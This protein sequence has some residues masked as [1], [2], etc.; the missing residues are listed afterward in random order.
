[1]NVY[2]KIRHKDNKWSQ[3]HFTIVNV[4]CIT[5]T[6][7]F[8]ST[9]FW[10]RA[11]IVRLYPRFLNSTKEKKNS[12]TIRILICSLK[13]IFL[14]T[15]LNGCWSPLYLMV[16]FSGISF[17][18]SLC[19]YHVSIHTYTIELYLLS[20]YNNIFIRPFMCEFIWKVTLIVCA[21]G[22]ICS[23]WFARFILSSQF[24]AMLP[25]RWAYVCGK[26]AGW[27]QFTDIMNW[28]RE[29]TA[30]P[31]EK[32]TEYALEFCVHSPYSTGISFE[33]TR[34][35]V[36]LFCNPILGSAFHSQ[37]RSKASLEE[38]EKVLIM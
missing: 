20:G 8:L 11:E 33:L 26:F 34:C 14:S 9:L 25:F 37:W 18:P 31:I 29:A 12:W 36:F 23:W 27:M 7:F 24:W 4:D 5:A 38:K 32:C 22:C 16:I 13:I 17:F 28:G 19:V 10:W 15:S 1:M 30:N 21:C 35:L 3:T 2:C 6:V